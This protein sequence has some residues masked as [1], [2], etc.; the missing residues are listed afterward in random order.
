M[1]PTTGT[2]DDPYELDL[3]TGW[4]CTVD[5]GRIDYV[6]A[7]GTARITIT[8]FSRHLQVYWWVDVYTRS[9]SGDW[10]QR[11]VGTGD[12]YRSGDAAARAAQSVVDAVADGE[13]LSEAPIIEE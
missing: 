5:D 6:D 9:G 8:E 10:T 7:D 2:D 3:P 13:D 11:E 1:Q 12:S 4:T